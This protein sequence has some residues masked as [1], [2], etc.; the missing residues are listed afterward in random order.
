MP[1]V[2]IFNADTGSDTTASGSQGAIV[3]NG[4][5]ASFAASVVT[6]DGSPDLS[7]FVAADDVLW[8]Q[9]DSGKQF[10]DLSSADD[11]ADTVTC[12]DAP[13]GTST[14]L[15]WGIGG[16]RA[17]W[18]DSDSRNIFSDFK[19][20]WT[21]ETETDQSISSVIIVDGPSSGDK[22]I[23]V[24]IQ[25]ST[26]SRKTIT[27]TANAS[28]FEKQGTT[29]N[30]YG[31][32][33]LKLQCTNG[34]KTLANGLDL[35]D[36]AIATSATMRVV[37]CELGDATNQL[38]RAINAPN[39]LDRFLIV[40]ITNC[41]VHDCIDVG[42]NLVGAQGVLYMSSTMVVDN[43][44]AGVRHDGNTRKTVQDCIFASNS[45]HGVTLVTGIGTAEFRNCVF[46]NNT[47]DGI[48][49][50]SFSVDV[51]YVLANNIFKDNGGW[52]VGGESFNITPQ[53]VLL[54]VNN[55]YHN[56]TSGTVEDAE[57]SEGVDAQLVDPQ[58]TDAA[59]NDFSIGTNLKGLGY[60]SDIGSAGLTTSSQD[61]GVSQRV[62]AAGGGDSGHP[63][64]R[65]CW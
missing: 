31:Y 55:A 38:N 40:E 23:M 62:E 27:Q 11:G 4:T 51:S 36:Q 24:F 5:A 48:N 54:N 15:T 29:T 6:L 37:D 53:S 39:T 8:L 63:T 3:A 43:G 13:A 52:G 41:Y 47:S 60:P 1:P 2:L 18:D 35:I 42:I 44:G 25:G 21:I 49:F 64:H 46:Y 30:S 58:F 50:I 33:R 61:I 59:N 57:L 19:N 26:G 34:T 17:T 7:G 45:G 22:F 56:N 9:T 12:V 20:S 14:G 65:F 28:H 10:F 16:K 32:R